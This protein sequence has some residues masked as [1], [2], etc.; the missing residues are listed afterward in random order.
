MTVQIK[1]LKGFKNPINDEMNTLSLLLKSNLDFNEHIKSVR[2]KLL[3]ALTCILENYG[4]NYKVNF[5]HKIVVAYGRRNEYL[6]T[7][8]YFTSLAY[9]KKDL[10]SS[11]NEAIRMTYGKKASHFVNIK[12][13]SKGKVVELSKR[14]FIDLN[15][16]I[17]SAISINNDEYIFIDNN[18]K[19]KPSKNNEKVTSVKPIKKAIPSN[20]CLFIDSDE[21]DDNNDEDYVEHKKVDDEDVEQKKVDDDNA[22]YKPS[23][24]D[25]IDQY[26]LKCMIRQRTLNLDHKKAKRT[27]VG[28]KGRL[29]VE[30]YDNIVHVWNKRGNVCEWIYK[31]AYEK[32]Y[33]NYIIVD[34]E[35]V[36][37]KKVDYDECLFVDDDDV[38][39]KKV[40]SPLVNNNECLFVDDDDA[41]QKKAES[42]L[43]NNDECLFI[44]DNDDDNVAQKRFKKRFKRKKSKERV[45]RK[46]VINGIKYFY[47]DTD[48]EDPFAFLNVLKPS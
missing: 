30:E 32:I 37:Q 33:K 25:Y 22:D 45:P 12:M 11:L 8:D 24:N 41:G 42:P 38:E 14:E 21:D 16:K 9:L 23:F 36:E 35:N 2:V 17:I 5:H 4:R 13:V 3:K 31:K 29:F 1:L 19:V 27:L 7:N 10:N 39:H 40:D 18:E 44:D 20:E 6:A 15:S 43:V 28:N 48:D 46:K 47:Y 26:D 34:E